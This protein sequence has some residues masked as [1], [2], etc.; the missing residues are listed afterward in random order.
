MKKVKIM[1]TAI[2]VFAVVSGALAFKAQRF[3]LKNVYCRVSSACEIKEFQTTDNGQASV[4]NP[5]GGTIT[6]YYTTNI[7]NSNC[8]NSSF[9]T[10]AVFPTSVD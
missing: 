8:S 9:K 7:G 10:T 4:T 1:L 5:C 3:G 6:T 2:T